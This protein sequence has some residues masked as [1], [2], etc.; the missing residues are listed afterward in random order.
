MS[1]EENSAIKHKQ[2]QLKMPSH[3]T[4]PKLLEH[5]FKNNQHT[6]NKIQ[7]KLYRK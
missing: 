7:G 6:C 2:I 4:L 5:V 3:K 1:Q